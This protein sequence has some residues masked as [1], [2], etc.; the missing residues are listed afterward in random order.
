MTNY[1]FDID[2]TLTPARQPVEKEF[3]QF[4]FNWMQD[5]HVYLV[6][7]SDFLKIKEQLSERI[8]NSC[9]GVFCSMANEFYIDGHLV[10]ENKL[11]LPL[12]LIQYLQEKVVNSKFP[13]RCNHFFEFRTG[14]LNYSI[15]GRDCTQ[16]QRLEY[17]QWDNQ[18]LERQEVAKYIN[19]NF[20]S[21]EACVG[22]QI[23]IDIQMKGNNKSLA[24]KWIRKN[25]GGSIYF[26]GDRTFKGGNDYDICADIEEHN[27]GKFFQIDEQETLKAILNSI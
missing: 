8:I 21:I 6:T 11:D 5:K 13:Y 17:Y 3:E 23:S 12:D 25:V 9:A 22:G 18:T 14:M 27:D 19:E 2:G 7:G 24:S 20:P 1:L 4:F 15:I 10:Y 16:A 26:F